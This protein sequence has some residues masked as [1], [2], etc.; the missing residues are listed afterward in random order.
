MST[1]LD[2]ELAVQAEAIAGDLRD[3]EEGAIDIPALTTE[4]VARR[5]SP[6]P[7]IQ[8]AIFLYLQVISF[9]TITW[10]LTLTLFCV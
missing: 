10:H 8:W 9:R 2:V 1:S 5:H 6:L 7:K 4:P 3:P